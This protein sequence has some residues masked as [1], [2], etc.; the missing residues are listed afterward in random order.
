MAPV[1]LKVYPRGN[2]REAGKHPGWDTNPSQGTMY[3]D[4]HL[5]AIY[6]YLGDER[7]LENPEEINTAT[8]LQCTKNTVFLGM[9]TTDR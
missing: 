8:G 5:E 9:F 6:M 3:I 1:D 2:G 4:S 7:K